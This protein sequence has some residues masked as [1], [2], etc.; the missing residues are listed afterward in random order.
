MPEC[1][2][3]TGLLRK[4]VHDFV[5]NKRGST[6]VG[7]AYDMSEATS[8]AAYEEEVYATTSR[9]LARMQELG[10]QTVRQHVRGSTAGADGDVQTLQ[11]EGRSTDGGGVDEAAGGVDHASEWFARRWDVC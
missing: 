1:D 2:D 11:H 7:R 4:A 10:L 8:R 6:L 5:E 3:K 9:V